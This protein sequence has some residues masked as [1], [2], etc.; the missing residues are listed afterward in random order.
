VPAD[1]QQRVAR[2]QRRQEKVLLRRLPAV[3]S[4]YFK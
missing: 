3:Y 4:K 1:E 2:E